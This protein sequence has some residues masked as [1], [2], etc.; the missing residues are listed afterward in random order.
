LALFIS[1][2]SGIFFCLPGLVLTTSMCI[3]LFQSDTSLVTLA[4]FEESSNAVAKDVTELVASEAAQGNIHNNASSKN[5]VPLMPQSWRNPFAIPL[6][7]TSPS[8]RISGAK[9]GL[10]PTLEKLVKEQLH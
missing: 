7:P 2:D 9:N 4:P 8:G 1:S 5:Y 10:D 3:E 6:P